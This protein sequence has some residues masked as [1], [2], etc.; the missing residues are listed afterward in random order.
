M[1]IDLYF[2]DPDPDPGDL[3]RQSPLSPNPFDVPQA[4]HVLKSDGSLC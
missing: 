1:Q 4:T 3:I 2:P